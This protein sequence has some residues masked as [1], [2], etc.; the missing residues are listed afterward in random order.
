M[1]LVFLILVVCRLFVAW[2][3]VNDF[4]FLLFDLGLLL[5]GGLQF[6]FT[7]L[8]AWICLLL[9]KWYLLVVSLCVL[10]GYWLL[11]RVAID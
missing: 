2:C 6:C 9:F 3:C 11:I 5:V 7:L 10:F 4:C 8:F 1:H